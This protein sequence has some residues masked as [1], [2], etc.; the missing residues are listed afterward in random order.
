MMEHLHVYS[1]HVCGGHMYCV[2]ILEDTKYCAMVLAYA[3]DSKLHMQGKVPV[4][5]AAM[6]GIKKKREQI[7]LEFQR[8]Y[9][10]YLTC[11]HEVRDVSLACEDSR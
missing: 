11:I 9:K 2:T 10:L 4:F 1:L 3:S 5:N 6:G 8:S 7:L